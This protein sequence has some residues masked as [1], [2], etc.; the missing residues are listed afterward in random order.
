MDTG[1]F[2]GDIWQYDISSNTWQ[3]FAREDPAP[4]NVLAATYVRQTRS[5]YFV[6]EGVAGAHQARLVRYDLDRHKITVLGAWPRTP[7][8]DRVFLTQSDKGQLVLAGSSSVLRYTAGVVLRPTAHSVS[9][10]AGFFHE[11]VLAFGPLLTENALTLPL[12]G[13]TPSGV[14]NSVIPTAE[15]FSEEKPKKGNGKA[16][17]HQIPVDVRQVL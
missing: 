16:W 15:L 5:L 4:R 9:I 17:G 11:S 14:A 10:E 2:A 12:E 3:P 7:L 6:D 1:D 13:P 8:V